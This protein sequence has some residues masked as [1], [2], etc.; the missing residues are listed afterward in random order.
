MCRASGGSGSHLRRCLLRPGR[1]SLSIVA[2][3]ISGMCARN[4]LDLKIHAE[5]F[6]IPGAARLGSRTGA[7]SADHLEQPNAGECPYS[8]A[9]STIATLMPDRFHSS[10]SR[11][12]RATRALDRCGRPPSRWPRIWIRHQPNVQHAND[13]VACL[14]FASCG[15]PR[16]RP[17]TPLRL[18]RRFMPC[19]GR[20]GVGSLEPGEQTDHRGNQC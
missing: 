19:A 5:Q 9:V 13:P 10:G 6:T 17:C 3:V 15:Y 1:R 14:Y 2:P 16:R 20:S 8:G 7:V 11:S 4:G 18:E 12:L